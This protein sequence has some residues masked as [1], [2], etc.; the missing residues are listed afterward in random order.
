[1]LQVKDNTNSKMVR[2]ITHNMLACH[3]RMCLLRLLLLAIADERQA[4]AQETTFPWRSPKW[5]W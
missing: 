4:I 1:M 3:V 5:N 2:L